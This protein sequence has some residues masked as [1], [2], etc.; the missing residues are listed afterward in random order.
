V[1]VLTSV[2]NS[3][4]DTHLLLQAIQHDAF[5]ASIGSLLGEARDTYLFAAK[6]MG[7]QNEFVSQ[8]ADL[9]T[10]DL[11]WVRSFY[12]RIATYYR[13]TRPHTKQIKLPLEDVPYEEQ[14][15]QAW[16]SYWQDEARHICRQPELLLT[17]LCAVVYADSERIL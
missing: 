2:E 4:G 14:L 1:P 13:F 10:C 11:L 3:P 12:G 16:Y 9:W 6:L 8:V 15:S 5:R 7:I 17:L